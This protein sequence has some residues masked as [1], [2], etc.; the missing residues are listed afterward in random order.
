MRQAWTPHEGWEGFAKLEWK[1]RDEGESGELRLTAAGLDTS[2]RKGRAERE[3]EKKRL[4]R[5][6]QVFSETLEV[7]PIWTRIGA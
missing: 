3:R 6:H 4:A 2:Y 5:A 1:G 7:L